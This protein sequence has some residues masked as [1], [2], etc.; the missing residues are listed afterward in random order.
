MSPLSLRRR[1]TA[2]ETTWDQSED[3]PPIA[4]A[5]HQ[6]ASTMAA[7]A[8][9]V[10]L[11]CCLILSPVGAAAGVLALTQTGTAPVQAAPVPDQSNDRAIVSEFAQRV[12]LT[13]LTA[14]QDNPDPLLA[15]LKDAPASA[16]SRDPFTA[17]DPTVAAIAETDGTWSVTVA[18]TV[19]D[20]R[21]VTARRFFQ[22]P[23]HLADGTVTALTLPA[24]VSP[25]PVVATASRDY[26]ALLG[27]SS[28]PGETVAQF[29]TAYLT[30]AGNVSRY[31]TPGTTLT[32][33]DPA[34]YTTVRLVDL[35]G[36]T[37][38]E[39]TITPADGQRMRVLATAAAE[40][41]DTQSA[42]VTYALTL[43]ARAGRWEITAIDPTPAFT[44]QAPAGQPAGTAP[45]PTGVGATTTQP[46][47][48]PTPTT[49]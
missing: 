30:G 11:W 42:N 16:L 3:L 46:G 48:T 7:K 45:T 19:T 33:L 13:W 36:D 25:P 22:V 39:P 47:T 32:A 40:V 5:P 29:L 4:D 23:I 26:G 21:E 28:A 6:V 12:V 35:R 31:L 38:V 24:P 41:T 49:P 17:H 15:L 1:P 20:A 2:D 34:P 37:D 43:T 14:T 9:T 18:V 8:A 27:A 44:P 10:L